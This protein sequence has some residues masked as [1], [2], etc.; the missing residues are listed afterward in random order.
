MQL[1]ICKLAKK[2]SLPFGD[3]ILFYGQKNLLKFCT[4]YALFH[5]CFLPWKCPG[6]IKSTLNKYFPWVM[7]F[8]A[9]LLKHFMSNF[10]TFV[11]EIKNFQQDQEI[12]KKWFLAINQPR[13]T[14]IQKFFFYRIKKSKTH[15]L[16]IYCHIWWWKQNQPQKGAPEFCE[17]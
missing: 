1:E 12:K 14:E 13:I 15:I 8:K 4:N 10:T 17:V 3:P 5:Q 16:C 7:G 2:E 9:H 11:L 6:K